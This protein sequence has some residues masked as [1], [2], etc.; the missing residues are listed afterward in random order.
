MCGFV[1]P[2]SGQFFAAAQK[3]YVYIYDKRGIE[4]HCCKEHTDVSRLEFLPHHFMLVGLSRCCPP[5]HQTHC[6]LPFILRSSPGGAQ[7]ADNALR[8][9]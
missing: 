5:L 1:D 9:G 3:K 7:M 6:K 8:I 4:I 2:D